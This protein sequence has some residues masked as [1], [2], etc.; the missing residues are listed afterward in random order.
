MWIYR[1]SL[2]ISFSFFFL[3]SLSLSLSLSLVGKVQNIVPFGYIYTPTKLGF[4][5]YIDSQTQLR[6][7][8]NA[9]PKTN[10][11]VIENGN[12]QNFK[13]LSKKIWIS[14]PIL[15][16]QRT[17]FRGET[18]F[19]FFFI[20]YISQTNSCACI[21]I[22]ENRHRQQ[23]TDRDDIYYNRQFFVERT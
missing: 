18:F 4:T 13:S 22:V 1:Y 20:V 5:M 7:S 16:P 14:K 21:V 3:L 15:C 23:T 9:P 19:H 2:S 11:E 17:D 10:M 8:L 12:S 6:T